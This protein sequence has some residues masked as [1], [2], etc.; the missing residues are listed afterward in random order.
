M[1]YEAGFKPI[2]ED[3]GFIIDFH[4]GTTTTKTELTL[5]GSPL[6]IE[7]KSDSLFSP[8]KS[9]SASVEIVSNDY[10]FDLYTPE[11][12]GIRVMV[13]ENYGYMNQNNSL[14]TDRKT[15]F[16]GYVV[17]NV[18][19]QTYTYLDTITIECV[20]AIS[21]LKDFRYTLPNELGF[22]KMIDII[23]ESIKDCGYT[24]N[25]YIEEAYDILNGVSDANA[26]EKILVSEANFID[27]DAERTVWDKYTI[28]EEI[29]TY[30]GLTL[31]IDGE[32][33][34][35]SSYRV[36]Y[37]HDNTSNRRF[38]IYNLSTD[39]VSRETISTLSQ[40]L[41]YAPGTTNLSLDGVYNKI[42]IS[43]NLYPI[44]TLVPDIDNE[45]G[46]IS[47]TEEAGLGGVSGSR[48][49][50]NTVH[51]HFLR[52]NTTE[53]DIVGYQYQIFCRFDPSKTNWKHYYYRHN[54]LAEC[55]SYTDPLSPTTHFTNSINQKIN[56]HC[57]LLQHYAYRANNGS[58]N[59][60]TSL[61]WEQY[62]TFFVS[63]DRTGSFS[64]SNIDRF[65]KKVLEYSTDESIMFKPSSGCSWIT[66]KGD[67]Y[68]S[69]DGAKYGEKNRTTLNIITDSMYQTAPVEKCTD[70]EESKYISLFRTYQN[71]PATYGTGFKIWKMGVHI[72]G[73]SWNGSGW[74]NDSTES[75]TFY[76]PYNN[77]PSNREDEYMSAFGWMSPVPN[78]DYT[79]KVGENAY[80]IPIDSKDSSAPSVGKLKIE[81]FTPKLVAD[82]LLSEWRNLFGDTVVDWSNLTNV[83]Y[84][85]NFDIDYVYTDSSVWYSQK[86]DSSNDD[87]VYTN[88]INTR[89]TNEFDTLQLKIN[90]QVPE[91]PISRSYTTLED[92]GY[93]NTI[94]SILD[95]DSDHLSGTLQENNII[96]LYYY[97]YSKSQIRYEANTKL[98]NPKYGSSI[99]PSL[100]KRY[101]FKNTDPINT[102]IS[103]P[104]IGFILDS[105]SVDYKKMNVRMSLVI[106]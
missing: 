32:D 62:L 49:S 87:V 27:D 83:I 102:D 15:L 36:N 33:V 30:L 16:R 92:G 88:V 51:K 45:D 98:E 58:N 21:T 26:I 31:S 19:D 97:H 66:I 34:W 71:Q 85:K 10:I 56:T 69:Y 52:K 76:I 44:D 86:E 84:C 96:D 46:H 17:P 4:T 67:L 100:V 18:Y 5:G 22:R 23:I 28:L 35:C 82:E 57:A 13:Y 37:E 64:L 89:Y 78:I 79:S 60:P 53:T 70:I 40:E 90:S 8:I 81:I 54:N 6:V 39:T 106:Y 59:L 55:D 68:Y 50:R 38:Y 24:G 42:E 48:W 91:R 25:L 12:R 99:S 9:R 47:V 74:V 61:D 7:T 43:S 11:S 63:D 104:E 14:I 95:Y 72:G 93:V 101:R 29:L 65:E 105:Y 77:N 20:D 94:H 41:E 3:R 2:T 75:V 80:C 73:K 103:H 1:I